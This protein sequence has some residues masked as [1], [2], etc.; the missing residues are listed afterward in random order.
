MSFPTLDKICVQLLLYLLLAKEPLSF[1]RLYKFQ[2][3]EGYKGEKISKPTFS[4]HLN[5]LVKKKLVTRTKTK[6][7]Q[8]VFYKFNREKW[9][10]LDEII[11][12]TKENEEIFSEHRKIFDS[13]TP[14]DQLEHVHF[15]LILQQLFKLKYEILKILNPENKLEYDW[16]IILYSN[17]W[18]N[19]KGW[20]IEN[21]EKSDKEYQEKILNRIEE[22]ITTY[23]NITFDHKNSK[24]ISSLH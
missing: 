11:K 2:K 3:V 10:K 16:E 14:S 18:N 24:D 19:Y 20:F 13:I 7:T 1:N 15:V 9:S 17:I 6:K 8:Y 12:R 21:L 22:L 5:H 4:L 23:D